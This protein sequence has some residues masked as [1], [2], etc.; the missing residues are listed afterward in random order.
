VYTSGINFKYKTVNMKEASTSMLKE[1]SI[2]ISIVLAGGLMAAGFYFSG[3]GA[4]PAAAPATAPLAAAPAAPTAVAATTEKID[5]ITED[6]HVKG[7]RNAPVKIVEYSDFEC[8]FCKRFHESMSALVDEVGGDELALVFR[9]FPLEQL[10]PVKA[11]AAAMASE[12]VGDIGGNDAFWKFTNGYFRDTLTNNRTDTAALI[13]KLV[14]EAGV[15]QA[16]FTTCFDGGQFQDDINADIADAIETGGR[17][18]PWSVMVG[19]S[20][21]T[22]P[23]NGAQSPEVIKQMIATALAEA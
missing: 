10:H 6:D 15:D 19:P 8:P 23:I 11:M 14:T 3:G 22:Y 18:T 13:P 20:G 4:Q 7:N 5:P 21:K 16:A 12:C 1:L 2:P 17:G 9:Q